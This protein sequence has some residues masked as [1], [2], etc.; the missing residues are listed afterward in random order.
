MD[1]RLILALDQGTTGST[2]L[3]VTPELEVIARAN[4]EF[5]QIYPKPGWVEHD[6]EAIYDSQ[7]K[8]IEMVLAQC[9]D[10]DSR[11]AAIGITNQRETTLLWDKNT[12]KSIYNAIVWQCRRTSAT[13]DTLKAE[14][15]E[16]IFRERTGL[17]LDAYFSGTKVT[18][19]LD[20]VEGAREKA[21]RGELAFGTVDSFLIWRL[22]EGARHVTDTTNAS[23]TLL[24]NIH[25]K[26]WD[27][28]LL[29]ILRCPKSI[30][31]EVASSSEVY[32][33]TLNVPGLRD[34]IPIAGIAGDQQSALFGQACFSPGDLKCTYGTGAFLLQNIGTKPLPSSQG[35][36]TTIAWT[37]GDETHYALEGSVFIAGAAVQWIR[38]GL[39]L[40]DAAP[41]IEALAGTVES[42]DGVTIVPAFVG[43]GAPYWDADARGAI[44]G[45]TR[46]TH[47]GHFARATLEAIAL[48]CQDLARAIE[49][50]SGKPVKA[51]KVDG[52]AAQNDLMMQIQS[53]LLNADII[54]PTQ[55]ETTALGAACLAGLAVGIFN[56]LDDIRSRWATEKTFTPN[57][58]QSYTQS[59]RKRWD[60]AIRCTREFANPE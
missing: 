53:D 38:D 54:R 4:V 27:D 36:L 11:I 51:L 44:Y 19:L 42:S 10:A 2:A 43:L 8:A 3:L 56:S 55:L 57:E 16:A 15:K 60:A 32:G 14:G 7:L 28:T 52:G 49:K 20:N 37:I 58:G 31:P 40:V 39:E 1:N 21:E 25:E 34:G 45:I 48:S 17:V 12:N 26:K 35:L 23:R 50:D 33:T 24:F 18:W 47:R 13:C 30:L 5:P 46:G 6:P 41:D 59:L 29:D 9:P 22:T